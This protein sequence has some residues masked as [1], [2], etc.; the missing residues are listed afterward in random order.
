MA[1]VLT[2]SLRTQGPAAYSEPGIAGWKTLKAFIVEWDLKNAITYL[3][4]NPFL[5][6]FVA[7]CVS[8]VLFYSFSYHQGFTK[9]LKGIGKMCVNLF[10]VA[11]ITCHVCMATR[12]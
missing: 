5:M 7:P 4:C 8:F 2:F 10:L 1:L 11:S 3:N 12:K 9:Y 6:H